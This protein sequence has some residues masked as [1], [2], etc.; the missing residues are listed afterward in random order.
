MSEI[1]FQKVESHLITNNP[2]HKGGISGVEA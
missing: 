2:R 1:G